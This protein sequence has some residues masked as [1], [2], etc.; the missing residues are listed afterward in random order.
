MH[1]IFGYIHQCLVHHSFGYICQSL[2]AVMCLACVGD[3]VMF[4]EHFT[5]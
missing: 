4:A 5:V 1:Q 2:V 3:M